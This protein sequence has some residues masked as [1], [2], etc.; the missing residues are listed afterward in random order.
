MISPRPQSLL[1][2]PKKL[3]SLEKFSYTP[4]LVPIDGGVMFG[5][6]ILGPDVLEELLA[7]DE[8]RNDQ[9]NS[10]QALRRFNTVI[11]TTNDDRVANTVK[12]LNQLNS[13]DVLWFLLEKSFA[14]SKRASINNFWI[15][16]NHL[17]QV[18]KAPI[19]TICSDA[20]GYALSPH[21]DNNTIVA[22]LQVY[23]DPEK[24]ELPIATRWHNLR[25]HSRSGTVPWIR[26]SG[27][28]N[29]NCQQTFHSVE[30]CSDSWRKSAIITWRITE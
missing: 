16:K 21:L 25:D 2:Q 12:L 5:Q 13:I 19:L 24:S 26:N 17:K 27:Y 14:G 3:I 6:N 15:T 22:N 11:T 1:A 28:F 29:V 23:L 8:W 7:W 4:E 9:I 30:N 18:L 10:R 20:P